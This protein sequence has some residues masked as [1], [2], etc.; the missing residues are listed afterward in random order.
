[1]FC[2]TVSNKYWKTIERMN[3]RS[4]MYMT[5]IYTGHAS[6]QYHLNKMK[7]EDSAICKFCEYE[8]ETV[9]HYITNCPYFAIKRM[10]IFNDY[11]TRSTN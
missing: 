2:P 6:L 7:I 4:A 10:R 8:Q 1:M 5:Q 11:T 9:E 3:R